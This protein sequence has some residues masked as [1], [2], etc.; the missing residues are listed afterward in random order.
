L[1]DPELRD[2]EE[3]LVLCLQVS[4]N[5][6]R[7]AVAGVPDAERIEASVA[8]YPT[9]GQTWLKVSGEVIPDSQAPAD[10]DWIATTLSSGDVV[11]VRLIE[12]DAPTAPILGRT[13]P[14]AAATDA[15][16][17]VCAF[18][19]KSHLEVEGMVASRRA[20]ICRGCI[21]YLYDT[22]QDDRARV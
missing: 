5:G 12:C 11:E 9:L 21:R 13:D 3:S 2:P 22:S 18:C 6:E 20:M 1:R 17:F 19:G 7:R 4:V 16:P 10:A 14:A 8:I 15:I